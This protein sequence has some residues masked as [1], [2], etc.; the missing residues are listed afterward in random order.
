MKLCLIAFIATAGAITVAQ[1]ASHSS[2][3]GQ[4][5][6]FAQAPSIVQAE[7][8]KLRSS[9]S[10][11]LPTLD[12]F[13]V[14]GPQ[15]LEVYQRPYYQCTAGVAA[16][17]SGGSRVS[18]SAKITAWRE[19]PPHSRYEV[20]TS[21]GRLES[22][23]LDRLQDAL[24]S[25][26]NSKEG[27][28]ESA[29]K[30]SPAP[31]ISAPMPQLP[32]NSRM[33]SAASTGQG[34]SLAQEAANLE[35]VLRNQ[36][37]PSNLVAVKKD[38]TPILEQARADAKVLF[39]ASAEDEFEILDGT[40]EWVHVRISGLSRGWLR[41]SNLEILDSSQQTAR[42]EPAPTAGASPG[43]MVDPPKSWDTASVFSVSGEQVGAFPGDWPTLKG[44]NVQIV[45]LQQ[46]PGSGRITSPQEKKHYAESVFKRE[47]LS[48]GAEGLVLIFDSEDGGMIAATRTVLDQWKARIIS[49]E[50]FWKKC[51]LD[52]P[53]ILGPAQ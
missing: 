40:P 42:D 21:N 18:V 41:R 53:E 28:T 37:H 27:K 12:G 36:A 50:A 13:V 9:T 47:E 23:L 16:L 46:A 19:D 39:L 38:Q 29:A 34:S 17:P 8:E 15:S 11:K 45:S 48:V 22:D 33:A 1:Q 6:T 4:E 52:P 30:A 14:P 35:E 44:K 51:L 31:D 2:I 25:K 7:I 32:K 20:L 5:R 26:E 3:S 10:G 24:A 49:D 43:A